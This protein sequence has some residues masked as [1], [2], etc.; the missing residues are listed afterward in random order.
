MS[1]PRTK[2]KFRLNSKDVLVCVDRRALLIETI[3]SL[4][5]KSARMGC[6]TGDC[7]ACTVLLDGKLRKPCLILSVSAD[8]GDIVT[9]EGS[10]SVIAEQVRQ[11]FV[12]KKGFQCGYCTSGMILIAIDLLRTK[13]DVTETEIRHA[14]SGNLCRCTGYDDIV[15]AIAHAAHALKKRR[16]AS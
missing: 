10:D 3:R 4:G 12:A 7:G 6:L 15:S 1:R 5:A 13:L 14:I 11:S 8:G 2:L 16:E 9:L